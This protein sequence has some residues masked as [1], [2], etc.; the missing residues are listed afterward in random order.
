M[1]CA[2]LI[3]LLLNCFIQAQ[4]T[5]YLNSEND[6]VVIFATKGSIFDQAR[7]GLV[8]EIRDDFSVSVIEIN[9][10]TSIGDIDSV[11]DSYNVPKA[12]VLIGNNAIRS[13]V[14]YANQNKQKTKSIQVVTILALDVQRA[15]SGIENVNAIAYETPMLT[16]LVSFRRVFS[17][18][19]DKVGVLYRNPLKQF[20]EKHTHYCAREKSA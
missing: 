4:D 14:K 8:N 18:P 19:V 15:V 9:E 13:Y 7:N 17:K 10:N 6:Q 20:I 1:K 2:L 11:I 16:A 3:V 12:V 5:E